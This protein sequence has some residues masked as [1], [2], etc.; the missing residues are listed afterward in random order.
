MD[1][2]RSDWVK[3]LVISICWLALTF[4]LLNHAGPYVPRAL[5]VHL[6]RHSFWSLALLVAMAAGLGASFL[7][8][9][10]PR[11]DLGLRMPSF[12][13][14]GG[15][16]LWA[17]IVLALSTYLAWKIGLPTILA[18]LKAGGRQAVQRNTG[19][20]GRALVQT[21]IA[22][23]IVWATLITPVAEELI[24][25]GGMWSA[26]QRLSRHFVRTKARSL[27]AELIKEGAATKGSRAVLHFFLSGGLA[28]IVT[29]AVFTWMHADQ[30]GGAGIIRLVQNACLGLAL[31]SARHASKSLWPGIALHAAYNALSLAKLRKWPWLLAEGSWPKPLPIPTRYWTLA[32][33]ALGIIVLW[34]GLHRLKGLHEARAHASVWID[35]PVETVFAFVSNPDSLARVF[36]GHGR[37]AGVKMAEVLD[38][39]GMQHGAVRRVHLA[40]GSMNDERILG[41]EPPELLSY[42]LEPA[43]MRAVRSAIGSLELSAA[44]GG[45]HIDWKH[46]L[47]LESPLLRPFATGLRNDFA[48]AMEL[49]LER[50]RDILENKREQAPASYVLDGDPLDGS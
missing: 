26:V 45:T 29:A 44:D 48:K 24:F 19:A 8:L 15:A 2:S 25:R 20:Y 12:G 39:G 37:V 1:R 30:K 46:I 3:L 42:E 28:T 36:H 10:K 14:M 41:F 34:W 35:R 32:A 21:H 47:V 49:A 27:P 17:P 40:D 7:L 31:G 9:D 23:T 22:T 11:E 5:A 33:V 16:M 4:L 43:G 13:S 6:S 50:S 38:E 18:E